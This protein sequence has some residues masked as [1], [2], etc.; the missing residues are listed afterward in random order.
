MITRR[1]L[2]F[3]VLALA[4]LAPAT[5]HADKAKPKS[6]VP[7]LLLTLTDG[8]VNTKTVSPVIQTTFLPPAGTTAAAACKGKVTV[9]VPI[10]KKTVKKKKKTIFV[11]KKSVVRPAQG[12]CTANTT[13]SLPGK[14]FGKTLKFTVRFP[15]NAAV[16]RFKRTSKL[17]VVLPPPPA[18]T[19]DP[20]KGAWII[21][22]IPTGPSSQQWKFTVDPDG[23]VS[24]VDRLTAMATTCPGAPSGGPLSVDEAPFDTPFRISAPDV[25]ATDNWTEGGQHADSVFRLHFDSPSHAT[26][27]F[28][29]TGTLL[30]P[31]PMLDAATLYP[32]CDSGVI[33]IELMPG[34]F[35]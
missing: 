4:L 18:P 26:G 17:A 35:G 5:A 32:G 34:V 6:S 28:Q 21:K 1:T 16:K 12:I 31:L 14:L 24:K 9:S 15:G 20:T 29:L 30:G 7:K 10:G 22:Q 27:T 2:T 13:L 25:T 11:A 33:N 19:L 23:T 3:L 8:A